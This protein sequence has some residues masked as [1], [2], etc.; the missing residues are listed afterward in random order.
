MTGTVFLHPLGRIGK[1]NTITVPAY[2]Y[3]ALLR[4]DGPGNTK[5]KTVGFVLPNLAPAGE[6]KDF[7]VPVN[8][9]ETLTG[10]DFWPALSSSVENRAESNFKDWGL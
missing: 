4:F 3:K 10:L 7:V 2:F 6:L 8:A 1:A 5:P 9:I